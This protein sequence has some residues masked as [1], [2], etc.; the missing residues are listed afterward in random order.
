MAILSDAEVLK[1]FAPGG[2]YEETKTPTYLIDFGADFAFAD[3]PYD[4]SIT[5]P[6]KII[7]VQ[8]LSIADKRVLLDQ[9]WAA[10]SYAYGA[11]ARKWGVMRPNYD[12]TKSNIPVAADQKVRDEILTCFPQILYPKADLNNPKEEDKFVFTIDDAK[13][14]FWTVR[15]RFLWWDMACVPQE[16]RKDPTIPMPKIR[17]DANGKE[18]GKQKYVYGPASAGVVWLLQADFTDTKNDNPLKPLFGKS[19]PF[20][21]KDLEKGIPSAADALK[22]LTAILG[23]KYCVNFSSLVEGLQ[24]KIFKAIDAVTQSDRSFSSLWCFQESKLMGP[25]IL[26]DRKGNRLNWSDQIN[27]VPENTFTHTQVNGGRTVLRPGIPGL[28]AIVT[29]LATEI[30]LATTSPKDD[31]LPEILRDANLKKA[32]MDRID[33]TILLQILL[34]R[35]ARSGLIYYP[36]NSPLEL[37]IAARRNRP[38]EMRY[39][40]NKYDAMIGVLDIVAHSDFKDDRTQNPPIFRPGAYEG[41]GLAASKQFFLDNLARYQWRMLLVAKLNKRIPEAN[42]DLTRLIDDPNDKINKPPNKIP[43]EFLPSQCYESWSSVSEG[44]FEPIRAYCQVFNQDHGVGNLTGLPSLN[45]ST[46]DDMVSVAY[47]AASPTKNV[48]LFKLTNAQ[49]V[50]AY[51]IEIDHLG[52]DRSEDAKRQAGEFVFGDIKDYTNFKFNP[53]VSNYV[54]VDTVRPKD[55]TKDGR[56]GEVFLKLHDLPDSADKDMNG[57]AFTVARYLA[58][59]LTPGDSKT[60]DAATVNAAP[61]LTG[62]FEGIV[63]ITGAS[64]TNVQTPLVKLLWQERGANVGVD[65]WEPVVQRAKDTLL[66]WKW[67]PNVQVSR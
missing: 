42:K 61:S 24:A 41:D 52:V 51:Q 27:T 1:Q 12:A 45:Y 13:A 63:D 14:I 57:K 56:P 21:I 11:A 44:L 37:I 64:F 38:T 22:W 3:K 47:P 50:V 23:P 62:V 66:F 65:C 48:T 55:F 20:D 59:R 5:F 60:A 10:V 53:G 15:K 16:D 40:K 36:E 35:L 67:L 4:P 9:G 54:S 28:T 31:R 18:V 33:G 8:K 34:H 30:S 29:F 26:V 32:G 39:P 19:L 43:Q 6:W 49:K 7:E 25:Q 2:K 46:A 17:K 58:I